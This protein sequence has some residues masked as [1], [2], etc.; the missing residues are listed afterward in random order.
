MKKSRPISLACM[1]VLA[2]ALSPTAHAEDSWVTQVAEQRS[3]ELPEPQTQQSNWQYEVGAGV[4]VAPEYEGSNTYGVLPLP[5]IS[6]KYKNGLFFANVMDGI[7]SYPFQGENYKVGASVGFAMGRDQDDDDKN[8]R[9]MGDVDAS[10]TL[11]L[12]GEYDLGPLTVYG[13]LSQGS[14]DYGTTAELDIGRM[15]PI[16]NKLRVM[17]KFGA[18][19]ASEDHMNS[20]FG[21]SSSQ[22]ARSGYSRYDAESGIKSVGLKVGTFY[23]ITDHWNVNLMLS[24]NQL[25][26]DAADSPIVKEEFQTMTALGVSYRF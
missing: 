15:F 2:I 5:Q 11:N 25:V 4:M 16:N 3:W 13:K 12:M 22:A 10:L 19:W 26:G 24:G 1:A 21:V 9:G 8:L 7:G 20:Y 18:K 6:A 14:E 17:G 23:S